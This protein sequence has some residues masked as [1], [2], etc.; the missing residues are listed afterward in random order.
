MTTWKNRIA[1]VVEVAQLLVTVSYLGYVQRKL[2][3]RR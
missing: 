1:R 3:D 2:Q